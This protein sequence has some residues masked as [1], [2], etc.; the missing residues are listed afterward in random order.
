MIEARLYRITGRV[1]G[2]GFR[3]FTYDAASREGVTG[4]VRNL[5]DGSVEV[6]AEGDRE[7]LARLDHALWQ[8]PAGARVDSV[9][10]QEV[11]PTGRHLE[12]SIRSSP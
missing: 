2:V 12:F 11:P 7:A 4:Y 8:G 1:H 5:P 3:M 10:L 9:D 6:L